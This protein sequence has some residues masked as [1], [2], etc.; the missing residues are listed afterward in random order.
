MA[1]LVSAR[2]G[3]LVLA[4]APALVLS[5]CT[6]TQHTAE[7]VRLE[8]ARQ[9]AALKPTR[10]T[11]AS[12]VVVATDVGIVRGSGR[13]AFVVSLRNSG[14]R[15]VSDLPISVGYAGPS[16]PATYLNAG[17]DLSYFQAHLPAIKAGGTLKWVFTT[18]RPVPPGSHPFARVGTRPAAPAKLTELNVRIDL[19]DARPTGRDTL[20]VRLQNASGVP[21]YQLQVYA[22]ASRAGRYLAAGAAT[23]A[24]LGAGA[25]Q[26]VKLELTGAAGAGLHVEAVPT[27]LQ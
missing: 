9:F 2:R 6:T 27:I 18:A 8:S 20:A 5:G 25:S 21:Q 23:V 14:S 4:V 17:S 22:Y 3:G 26:R 15:A 12:R 19:S 10:V 13:T 11:V 16:G 7:R 1:R 24:D